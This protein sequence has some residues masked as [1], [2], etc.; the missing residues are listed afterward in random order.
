MQISGSW[1]VCGDGV[2]RPVILGAV[3]TVSGVWEP[4]RF[5]V[6]TGADCTA[7]SADALTMLQLPQQIAAA[8]LGGVGG[9]SP[10]V[11]VETEIRL[12]TTDKHKVIFKGRFAA[13]TDPAAIDMSVLGRDITNLFALIVDRPGDMVTLIGQRHRNGIEQV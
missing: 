5:L 13:F 9:A 12:T 4:V 3:L 11:T 2:V 6:D 1:Y 8:Q 7:F 10:T